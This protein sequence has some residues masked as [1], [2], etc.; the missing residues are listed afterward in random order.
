MY[1]TYT[2]S[3]RYETQQLYQKIDALRFK[4]QFLVL[5]FWQTDRHTD[6][7]SIC[8]GCSIIMGDSDDAISGLLDPTV[9]KIAGK[10][11]YSLQKGWDLT[12]RGVSTHN[13]QYIQ[14]FI[15]Q[16]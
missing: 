14:V 2:L 6:W 9:F 12:T 11:P 16:G 13:I 7:H 10:V 8:W 1:Y 15:I 3:S 5:I 4:S